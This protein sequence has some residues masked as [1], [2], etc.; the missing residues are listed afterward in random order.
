M[1]IR[2][3]KRNNRRADDRLHCAVESLEDRRLFAADTFGTAIALGTLDGKISRTGTVTSTDQGD[4]YKFTMPRTGGFAMSVK[5][6]VPDADIY[7]YNSSQVEILQATQATYP[8]T[9]SNEIAAG[10]YYVL[11]KRFSGSPINYTLEL[12]ADFAGFSTTTA[13]NL[14][15]LGSTALTAK[16]FVGTAAA[17]ADPADFH[18][19]TLSAATNVNFNLAGMTA[20]ANLTI[21]NS[22]GGTVASS[23]NTGTTAEN[24][25]KN[26]AAGTYYAKVTPATGASTNYTLTIS[27]STSTDGAGN[28]RTL[29]KS[30]GIV[31]G[32]KQ[33]TGA[34]SA[35]PTESISPTDLDD[36][37]KFVVGEAGT[38]K[39]QLTNLTGNLNVWFENAAGTVLTPKG[40]NTGTTSESIS[41]SVQP[42]VYYLRVFQGTTGVSSQ[43]KLTLTCPVDAGGT[44]ATALTAPPINSD[45][46][47]GWGVADKNVGPDDT[48]D[49][50]K[51]TLVAGA[52]MNIYYQNATNVN[53][54][55]YNSAGTLLKSLVNK[56]PD[57]FFVFTVPANG[58]YF[59]SIVKGSLSSASFYDLYVEY[60]VI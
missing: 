12:H 8:D 9:A 3:S 51:F 35:A 6:N 39:A 31:S 46:V 38:I 54:Y 34:G 29:A 57:E 58:S 41:L 18:K 2:L 27:K 50:Y 44:I 20:N 22:T 10:T 55:L 37:Y 48:T 25:V 7:L 32:A 47:S 13:R 16:D 53:L 17:E 43:Y 1:Q 24:I 36:F 45:M 40:L 60:P 28:N 59:V 42:G 26:L 15:T 30:L 33:L 4:Y 23:S 49:F 19:F 52:K 14:G 11:V 56:G 21:L 5:G